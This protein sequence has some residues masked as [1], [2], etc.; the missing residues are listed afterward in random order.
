MLV[1]ETHLTD[2]SY[3]KIPRYRIYDTKHPVGKEYGG[4]AVIIKNIIDHHKL[5][6]YKQNHLGA[7]SIKIENDKTPLVISAV[8]YPP[9]HKINKGLFTDFFRILG[10]H[11]I[12]RGDYNAKHPLWGSR[13]T[14]TRGRQLHQAIECNSLPHLSTGEPTYRNKMPD[15]LDYC[16]SKGI[17][18]NYLEIKSC[19]D[20]SSDHTPIIGT[21]NIQINK[22]K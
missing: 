10:H 8:Y 18:S 2:K 19:W 12:A 3:M 6:E 11:F 15:L 22:K 5:S 21:I 20:L 4:T 9:K 7:T 17:S 16:V 1:S 14:T 13:L